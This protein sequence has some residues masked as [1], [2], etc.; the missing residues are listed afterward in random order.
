M[1]MRLSCTTNSIYIHTLKKVQVK[2][3]EFG[4][5]YV[6]WINGVDMLEATGFVELRYDSLDS[7]ET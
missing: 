4:F 6:R 5:G 3:S 2:S 1:R 7:L